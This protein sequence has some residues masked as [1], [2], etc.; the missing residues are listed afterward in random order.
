MPLLAVDFHKH[1]VADKQVDAT[2]T[3]ESGL[4]TYAAASLDKYLAD[5]R[6]RS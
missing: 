5:D 6:L 3:D 4:Y 2:D 1:P